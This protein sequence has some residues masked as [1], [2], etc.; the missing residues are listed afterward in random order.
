VRCAP[1]A[2]RPTPAEIAACRGYLERERALLPEL[3][4]VVALG[5]IAWRGAIEILRAGAPAGRIPPF[6]HGAETDLGG[7]RLVASYHPSQQ[8]TFTG[9]LT[10]PMLDRVLDRARR[11]A[12]LPGR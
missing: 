8:N 5:G 1:P 6:G 2:N 3:R 10:P 11:V 9:R 4:V 7:L 12:E